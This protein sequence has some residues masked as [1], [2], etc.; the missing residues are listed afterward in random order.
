MQLDRC[1]ACTGFLGKNASACP[2][3]GASIDR[4]R[5]ARLGA[6]GG[7]LGG[8][9]LAFTLMACYGVAPPPRPCPD[10]ASNCLDHPDALGP[11]GGAPAK[12][13]LADGGK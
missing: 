9:A 11:D 13:T 10:G 1:S 7:V 3:C 8:G 5:T 12:P 6:I 2:H 4:S